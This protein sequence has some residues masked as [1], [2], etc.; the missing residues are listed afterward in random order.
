[1]AQGRPCAQAGCDRLV[2]GAADL[3][4]RHWAAARDAEW[5]QMNDALERIA[6]LPPAEQ[7]AHW[8]RV[9]AIPEWKRRWWLPAPPPERPKI[10]DWMRR[11]V[12]ERD[13]LV[14]KLCQLAVDAGDVH[15]DHIVP[16]SLG[17]PTTVD[18]LRVTHAVCN[19]RRGNRTE[20]A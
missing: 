4:I 14:C 11:A 12:I 3:C 8:Q 6:A 13:G 16:F 19:L 1:M 17:G 7:K 20:T 15:L 9:D 2:F 5:R 10:P 18:N